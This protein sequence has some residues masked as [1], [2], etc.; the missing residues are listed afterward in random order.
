MY[1]Q[2][3]VTHACNANAVRPCPI[4]TTGVNTYG[5][6]GAGL[7][8]EGVYD[9]GTLAPGPRTLVIA[10][11]LRYVRR[12]RRFLRGPAL[13]LARRAVRAYLRLAARLRVRL[14][15]KGA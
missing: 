4:A 13:E 9:G 15:L 5:P 10:K 6:K 2:L 14:L 12:R 8:S 7:T 3:L 11:H 1:R